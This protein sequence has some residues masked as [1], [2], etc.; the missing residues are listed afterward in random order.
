MSQMILKALSSLN[1]KLTEHHV[2]K[3]TE[4]VVMWELRQT[5]PLALNSQ[6]IGI[7]PIVF[8]NLDRDVLFS[9]F[10]I[11]QKDVKTLLQKCSS[12]NANFIV[13]SDPF[14]IFSIW[15]L[16][17]A[18]R[19]IRDEKERDLFL[20]AVSKYIHYRFF[21][22]LVNHY[23]PYRAAESY[24]TAAI[25][26][27]S[28]KFDIVVYGTWKTTI[29]ARCQDLIAK[30][31]IHRI[32]IETA[33]DDQKFLYVI[34]DIQSRIRDK[35]KKITSAYYDARKTGNTINSR[36][37]TKETEDGKILV[38]TTKVIDVMIFNLQNEIMVE[39]LFIDADTVRK[40]SEQFSS[41]TQDMLRNALSS[42]IEIAETQR[43]S[44]E[45]DLIK[46]N[47]GCE[48]YIGIRVFLLNL[49]QKT[50]RHCIQEGVDITNPAAIYIKA[51]NIYSSSRVI[52]KD[53]ISIKQSI[54]Y[55]VDIISTSRRETTKGSLRLAI[56][57]YILIRSFRFI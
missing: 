45:L 3:M 9:I 27:L 7:H 55:L 33:D 37:S 24:M 14:N 52:D 13:I 12:I 22:S 35:I 17:L 56:L 51:K 40:I 11:T 31:S 32:S 49:I 16:H 26:G 6:G 20:L 38:H 42:I 46:M 28:R 30:N 19:D 8:T 15:L 39:R 21:T 44:R 47:D 43:D 4:T 10:E 48:L 36:A 54:T 29:E 18:F 5:H 50:Y 2:K 23:F 25:S 1:I 34:Q 57:M 41:I 53:I